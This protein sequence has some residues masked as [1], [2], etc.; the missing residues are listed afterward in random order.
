MTSRF[1]CLALLLP[2]IATAAD[3]LEAGYERQTYDAFTAAEYED[4][5]TYTLSGNHER[6]RTVWYG[7][8]AR[9]ERFDR[10][11]MQ[12]M[13]GT[14]QPLTATGQLHG[15]AYLTPDAD[16]RPRQQVYLGWYQALPGGWTL[17]PGYQTTRYPDVQVSRYNLN[18]ERYIGDY[19]LFYGIAD[20]RLNG[21]SE[22][23][24]RI[25]ADWYRDERSR[26][27]LGTAWGDDQEVDLERAGE[28][29]IV[30]PFRSWYLSAVQ[31]LG[32]RVDLTAQLQTTEQ[33]D[34]YRQTGGRLGLRYH[35]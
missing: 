23:N 11:D 26:Y 35:F 28:P 3:W 20:V 21:N 29:V 8:L 12:L 31:T 14:Y 7:E 19:R 6:G 13:I 30:T 17:E 9:L 2:G 24:H 27:G 18:I 16:F 22:L 25:Q 4:S 34:R 15:E 5:S 10:S 1:A 32:S 33:E